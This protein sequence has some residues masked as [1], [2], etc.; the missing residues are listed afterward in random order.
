MMLRSG[1][2]LQGF[3]RIFNVTKTGYLSTS[4][5]V[6]LHSHIEHPCCEYVKVLP[7]SFDVSV[8]Y[9]CAVQR[10]R[11]TAFVGSRN[12]LERDIDVRGD[13]QPVAACDP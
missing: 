12:V 11:E 4:R 2:P 10:R 9:G 7:D 1:L 13:A 5:S 3:W 8:L 6:T